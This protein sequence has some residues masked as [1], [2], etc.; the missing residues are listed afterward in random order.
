MKLR[1]LISA[2]L[3][4]LSLGACV[5]YDA[6]NPAL[7]DDP[8]LAARRTQDPFARDPFFADPVYVVRYDRFGR[9]FYVPVAPESIPRRGSW[10]GG[11]GGGGGYGGPARAKQRMTIEDA[12]YESVNGLR[13][14]A[15][16]YVRDECHGE[17]NCDVKA[18]SKKLG[19]P[20]AG[21]HKDLIVR[22]RCGNGP[23]Q[24]L[25]VPE[26]SEQDIRC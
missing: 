19:D 5:A 14:D 4:A 13:V 26:S 12:Q 17:N 11:F 2:T 3:A 1:T 6:D 16:R 25:R 23:S 21:A 8:T 20:D 24:T 9:P 18:S 7:Y 22:Y 10:G 15:N